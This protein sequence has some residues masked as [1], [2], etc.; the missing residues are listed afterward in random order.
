VAVGDLRVFQNNFVVEASRERVWKFYTNIR[1]LELITPPEMKLRILST[2]DEVIKE[3]S[4]TWLSAKIIINTKWHSRIKVLEPYRYVDE[5]VGL[6]DKKVSFDYWNHEHIFEGDNA[7]TT[8]IDK[9]MFQLPF[10]LLG[11][12]FDRIA[13]AKLQRVFKYREVATERYFIQ[14]IGGTDIW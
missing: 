4:E 9:I 5:M 11:K 13:S 12:C 8:I 7:R 1:H 6:K 14:K 2:S 3:G 10:G